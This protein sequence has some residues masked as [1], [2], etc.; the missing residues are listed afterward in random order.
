L[1]GWD[2][3]ENYSSGT[4]KF[5]GTAS[6][7][8]GGVAPTA[9]KETQI[10]LQEG[11]YIN[12]VWDSRWTPGSK[13]SGP[14]GGSYSPNGALPINAATA[15]ETRGLNIPGVLNNAE[16]GGVFAPTRNIP[17]TL[18]TSIGGTESELLIAPQYRQYL[19]LIDESVSTLPVGR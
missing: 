16:R 3:A 7:F 4:V 11:Q 14:F 9:A 18:R 6:L 5:A 1:N 8:A 19:N 10:V 13:F 12:R 17:A 2:I 15:V